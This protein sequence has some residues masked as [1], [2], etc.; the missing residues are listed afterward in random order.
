MDTPVFRLGDSGLCGVSRVGFGAS[1]SSV[2]I[3][4]EQE[5]EW[6]VF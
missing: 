2:R 1:G 3:E 5:G 6:Q 4:D